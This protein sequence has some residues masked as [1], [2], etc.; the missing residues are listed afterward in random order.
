M[1]RYQQVEQKKS[2]QIA[3]VLKRCPKCDSSNVYKR[4]RAT[5]VWPRINIYVCREC[6]FEFNIPTLEEKAKIICKRT[7]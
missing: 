5:R 3:K 6:K 2:Q 1:S 7:Y 4:I